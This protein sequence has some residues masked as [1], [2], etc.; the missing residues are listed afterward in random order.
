[1]RWLRRANACAFLFGAF[2][3]NG[4]VKADE[5]DKSDSQKETAKEM[6]AEQ[7]G[8]EVE[9]QHKN[10]R[11]VMDTSMG[12][13]TIELF[14]EEA[15]VTTENFLRYVDEGFYDNTVFHRV[16]ED[17][18]IQGGGFTESMERKK[19]R[20]AIRN[21]ANNGLKNRRGTL[22]MARTNHPQSATSQFFIN[23]EDNKSLDHVP[24]IPSRFGYAVFAEVVEGMDVVDRIRRVKT[25]TKG[26]LK[27]VPV[28]PVILRSVRRAEDE[29]EAELPAAK[30]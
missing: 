12:S 7:E 4:P 15:P 17:F 14:Q 28:E 1:M 19:T 13:F 23:V 8:Q 5:E 20:Q 3:L 25:T 26:G 2:L 21:E 22:S 18:V 29:G 10:P 27:D 6:E 11:L 16:I 24:G 30:D 9:K